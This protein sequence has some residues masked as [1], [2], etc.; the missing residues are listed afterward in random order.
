[1]SISVR[2]LA[3]DD[4][5]T[6]RDVR[7]AALADAPHAFGSSL[8]KEQAYEEADWRDWLQPDR[9]MKAVADAQATA[10]GLVGA[11]LPGDRDGAVELYSMWVQPSW[12]GRGF[13]DLLITEVLD[14]ARAGNHK[15]VDL[16]VVDGNPT[17]ERL[18]RRHG[19]RPTEEYQP[20]PG[21]PG[22]RERVMTLDLTALRPA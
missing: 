2:R 16:W 13:G 5:Q 21:D 20:H 11:W 9:G 14:W 6:W 1:M 12:R 18:Y 8:A 3:P 19:F 7:L 10:V 22:V 15:R 4:W 17:A